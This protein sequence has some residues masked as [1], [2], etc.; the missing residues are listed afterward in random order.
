MVLNRPDDLVA[1]SKKDVIVEIVET[2]CVWIDF[3]QTLGNRI[4]IGTIDVREVTEIP[5][6][7]FVV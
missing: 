4:E 2:L 3:A 5:T 6:N 1:Y 7:S